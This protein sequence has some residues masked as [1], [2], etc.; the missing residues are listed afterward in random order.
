MRYIFCHREL[1]QCS[2]MLI[3]AMTQLRRS[4]KS[5]FIEHVISMLVVPKH[6]ELGNL[7]QVQVL[8]TYNR[9]TYSLKTATKYSS[10][11]LVE[12]KYKAEDL[13]ADIFQDYEFTKMITC[14]TSNTIS[15]CI[16]CCIHIIIL[17]QKL[18]TYIQ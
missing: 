18:Y 11:S 10:Y 5:L 12:T 9:H 14:V 1:T 17:L 3:S 15:Y 13:V 16:T 2:K 6:T 4:R 7:S 8:G